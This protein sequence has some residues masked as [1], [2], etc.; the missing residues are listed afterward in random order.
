[1]GILALI[2]HT[3]LNFKEKPICKPENINYPHLRRKIVRYWL[4]YLIV[5]ETKSAKLLSTSS[6]FLKQNKLLKQMNEIISMLFL[7]D[8]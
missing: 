6:L 7:S 4:E 1:M 2:A 3:F 8:H 5:L